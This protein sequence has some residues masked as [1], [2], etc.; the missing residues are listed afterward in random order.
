M[1]EGETREERIERLMRENGDTL[2]RLCFMYLHDAALAEDAA[3]EA[4]VKAY[5]HLRQFQG[6][7]EEK[8][9]LTRIAINACKD[10]L[11]TPY[12]RMRQRS[13]T[14]EEIPYG[15]SEPDAR[16]ETV[17]RTVMDLPE[18]YRA[19]VLLYY[20]QQLKLSEVA[21]VLRIPAPT[22]SSRLR[23]ARELLKDR[24]EGWYFDGKEF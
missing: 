22:V 3:Q 16:D 5:R 19:V 8:T 12:Q 20:Y 2:V 10:I 21:H 11:R 17:L 1:N 18:R 15:A 4:F 7:S 14:L 13:V 6:K 9:W 24:L 23:R